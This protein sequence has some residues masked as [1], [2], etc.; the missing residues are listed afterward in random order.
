MNGWPAN[1]SAKK[2]WFSASLRVVELLGEPLAQLVDERSRIEPGEHHAEHAE[3]EIGVHEVG[4]DRLVDTRV[5]HLHRDRDARV[6][7]RAVHLA[8]RRGGDRLGI[9][10]REHARRIVAELGAH[11]LRGELGRHRRRVL[12]QRRRARREPARAGR[13]RGSWPS[14]RSSSARPSCSRARRQPARRCAAGSRP[15]AASR[16][17]SG[18]GRE[19]RPVHRVRRAR[20]GADR[21]ELGVAGRDARARH[22]PRAPAAQPATATNAPAAAEPPRRSPG[23]DVASAQLGGSRRRSVGSC[24]AKLP[25]GFV[26]LTDRSSFSGPE[27]SR[28]RGRGGRGD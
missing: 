22:R 7:H 21:G 24:L 3:Q 17:S 25:G 5:L 28:T 11:D 2:R 27:I 8:D 18:R 4:A 13:R 14:G 12:L 10:L 26:H 16:R 1:A 15:R 6:R 23:S 20:P 9:P 19:P